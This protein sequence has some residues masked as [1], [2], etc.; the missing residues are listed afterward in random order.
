MYRIQGEVWGRQGTN[1]RQLSS[2]L[3]LL[4]KLH[5][6]LSMPRV[7]AADRDKGALL[8]SPAGLPGLPI[9]IWMLVF[10]KCLPF[11]ESNRA[12]NAT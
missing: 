11:S 1:A 5:R 8:I 3:G 10:A 4:L 7:H 2:P 9:R 6:G 12:C